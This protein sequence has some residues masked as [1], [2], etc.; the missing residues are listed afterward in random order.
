MKNTQDIELLPCP[1]CGEREA[2]LDTY[3]GPCW[4]IG[5]EHFVVC[6]F[7]SARGETTNNDI[8]A[9]RMW[10]TRIAPK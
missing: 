7:C 8:A 4:G 1:F 5:I 2:E 3:E 10:N 9:M 6:R